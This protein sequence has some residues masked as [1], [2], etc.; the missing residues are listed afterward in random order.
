MGGLNLVVGGM[1]ARR[2][3][4]VID[5]PSEGCANVDIA[6]GAAKTTGRGDRGG[7]SLETDET[8]KSFDGGG[9][10]AWA[11]GPRAR[12]FWAGGTGGP[13]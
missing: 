8:G 1:S 13:P 10:R 3:K 6:A 12:G 5:R 9:T 11:I 4:G 2:I 7:G